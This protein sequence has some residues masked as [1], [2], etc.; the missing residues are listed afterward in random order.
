MVV[1]GH[2]HA[3]EIHDRD[4]VV[5]ANTGTCSGGRRECVSIDTGVR[6]LELLCWPPSSA[7]GDAPQRIDAASIG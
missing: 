4:G 5:Y 1:L 2:T 7:V 3:A 6:M